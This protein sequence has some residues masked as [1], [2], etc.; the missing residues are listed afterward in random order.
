VADGRVWFTESNA[1]VVAL[2]AKTGRL[3]AHLALDIDIG[4]I[5]AF[6]PSPLVIGDRVVAPLA[7]A[8]LGVKIP[9]AEPEATPP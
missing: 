4:N 6:S 2:D 1:R 5:Q 3:A 9:A 7:M 8:L